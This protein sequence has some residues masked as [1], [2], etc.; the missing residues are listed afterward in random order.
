M[1]VGSDEVIPFGRVPDRSAEANEIEA[2][3]DIAIRGQANAASS[4]MASG[5]VL[6][7]NPYGDVDPTTIGADP[8]YVPQ[9]AVGRL[10]ETPDDIE[11]TIDSYTGSNGVRTPNASFNAAYDWMLSTGQA[12][13]AATRPAGSRLELPPRSSNEHLDAPRREG[14]PAVGRPRLRVHQRA[15]QHVAVAGGSRLHERHDLARTS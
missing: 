5:Y 8:L 12:V 7:D 10:V 11:S 4:A 2:G 14:R 9:L 3:T 1:V 6:S 15:L 13:D